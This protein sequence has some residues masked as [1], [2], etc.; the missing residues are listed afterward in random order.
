MELMWGMSVAHYQVHHRATENR[1]TINLPSSHSSNWRHH[2]FAIICLAWGRWR[3]IN[4]D[5]QIDAS[6]IYCK[7]YMVVHKINGWNSIRHLI[8]RSL[9]NES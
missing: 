3:L 8:H 5:T 2:L 1:N 9:R 4:W 6:S 7:S